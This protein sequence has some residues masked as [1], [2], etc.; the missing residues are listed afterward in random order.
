MMAYAAMTSKLL[1]VMQAKLEMME[2]SEQRA[3]AIYRR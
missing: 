2:E 3:T 1:F